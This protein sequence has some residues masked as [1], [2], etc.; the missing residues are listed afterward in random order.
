MLLLALSEL[1][2]ALQDSG[3]S[4]AIMLADGVAMV[5]PD[6]EPA[7]T[8]YTPYWQ[9][10]SSASNDTIMHRVRLS[11]FA[12]RVNFTACNTI[13]CGLILKSCTGCFENAPAIGSGV[14]FA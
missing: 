9:T 3:R 11:L 1:K 10:H 7:V 5:V 4:V 6:R 14:P 8:G 2:E 13:C 12:Q